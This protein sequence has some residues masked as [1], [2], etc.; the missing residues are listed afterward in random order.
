MPTK[1][2]QLTSVSSLDG[3]ESIPLVQTTTKK[4]LLSTIADYIIKTAS[5]FIQAATGAVSETL[6]SR[7][8]RV[9]Y[10]TDFMTEAQRA[11]VAAGTLALDVTTALQTAFAL[12]NRRVFLPKG[13]YLYSSDLEPTCAEIIG[14]GELASVLV[15][16]SAVTNPFILG[17]TGPRLLEGFQIDGVNTSGKIGIAIGK[18]IS[19]AGTINDVLVKRFT[20]ANAAN[21]KITRGLKSRLSRVTLSGGQKNLIIDGTGTGGYPTSITFDT[22]GCIDALDV[23]CEVIECE[24]ITFNQPFFDSNAKEAIKVVPAASGTAIV[25]LNQPRFEGNWGSTTTE[26]QVKVDGSAASCRAQMIMND[27]QFSGSGSSAKNLR[28]TGSGANVTIKNPTLRSALTGGIVYDTNAYGE[29]TE[30]QNNSGMTLDTVVTDSLNKV[31]T[32]SGV[33]S[34]RSWTPAFTDGAGTGF[35]STTITTARYQLLGKRVMVSLDVSWTLAGAGTPQWIRVTVPTNLTPG[36]SA[37]VLGWLNVG[38]VWQ[39]GMAAAL[40]DGYIYFRKID[41]SNFAAA[42]TSTLRIAME[43][44][45]P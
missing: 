8:R 16:T 10:V 5:S 17:N 11:D 18:T 37:T 15:P 27:P 3:T 45:L 29:I 21:M 41:N 12:T 25:T 39:A 38:G 33:A 34:S 44:F 22:L 20:G 2:S 19:W 6:Q 40:T 14:E 30:W 13:S 26:Y 42:S 32:P 43:Y 36:Y 28:A 23:G 4:S 1:I 31:S 9:V 7:G 35:A 24:T